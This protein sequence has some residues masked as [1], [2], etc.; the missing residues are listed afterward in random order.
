M[1]SCC[2]IFSFSSF[3]LISV[4]LIAS[5]CLLPLSLFL[6]LYISRLFALSFSPNLIN[7]LPATC[8]LSVAFCLL[9]FPVCYFIFFSFYLLPCLLCTQAGALTHMQPLSCAFF[10]LLVFLIL[11]FILLH[12]LFPYFS[13][14]LSLLHSCSFFPFSLFVYGSLLLTFSLLSTSAFFCCLC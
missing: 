6:S 11:S 5:S 2:F 14:S 9:L 12:L 7:F 1:L 10:L 4:S 8:F 3:I 13:L